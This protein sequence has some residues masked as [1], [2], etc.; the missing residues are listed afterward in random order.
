MATEAGSSPSRE[1]II[2]RGS[3]EFS[4]VLA[5]SDGLFAIAMT[6][7]VVGIEVPDLSSPSEGE[8]LDALRDLDASFFGFAISFF[9]IGRY[10]IAHH[11]LFGLLRGVDYRFVWL[12]LVYLAFVAFLPFP[13]GVLGDYFENPV[14]L[15]LYA[16]AAALVSGF[17]VVLFRHAYRHDLLARRPPDDVYR[18]SLV[19]S[20]MPVAF[21]AASIPVAF[22][23]TT[24]GAILWLGVIPAEMLWSRR[25]PP[26]T[27]EY[28]G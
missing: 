21:F 24:L 12:N 25:R 26:D 2:E 4:R 17:E 7:L 19:A 13:T 5:F 28:V 23:S 27:D 10:W 14:A 6:L 18:W 15:G 16:A 1:R 20:L 8:L 3:E 9:V 11:Q 22:A